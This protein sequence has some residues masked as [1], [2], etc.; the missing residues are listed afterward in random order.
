MHDQVGVMIMKTLFQFMVGGPGPG[1]S[2]CPGWN[3]H[4][5]SEKRMTPDM[6]LTVVDDRDAVP[7]QPI[8][9]TQALE[10]IS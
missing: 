2:I 3:D 9:A 5:L 4:G 8:D 10:P 7:V 1:L 6:P